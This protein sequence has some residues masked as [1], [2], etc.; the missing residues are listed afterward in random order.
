MP[1]FD[2]VSKIDLQEVDN[3]VNLVTREIGN[4][5]DFKNTQWSLENDKKEEKLTIVA[6]SNYCLEQIQNS[7][8]GAF[9]KR[10][11]DV[12]ALDFQEPE[13]ASGN[14]LRQHVKIREGIDQ[15]NAKKITKEVKGNKMKVQ[16]SI[17][18]NEL[19]ASGK[20]RDDLQAMMQM[21]NDMNLELPLQF[22][23][24]RD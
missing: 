11:L 20:K 22:V 8:K 15:E 6:E 21:I 5:Y 24:F 12:R 1:S 3:A 17:Q 14:S 13:K 16:V 2:I 19:R 7:L 23:N 4:R 10:G 18:G 9:V